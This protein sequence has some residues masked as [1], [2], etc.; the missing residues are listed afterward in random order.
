ML[1]AV[2]LT[3]LEVLSA[4]L[5]VQRNHNKHGASALPTSDPDATDAAQSVAGFG[6]SA[7]LGASTLP[8]AGEDEDVI[9]LRDEDAPY[10]SLLDAYKK[11]VEEEGRK[12]LYRC[13]WLTVIAALGAGFA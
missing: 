13:W 6:A 12:T 4:R 2:V 9:A 7:G 3:P 5:S 1:S 8:Y 11:V 10:T